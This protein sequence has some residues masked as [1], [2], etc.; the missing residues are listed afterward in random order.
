MRTTKGNLNKAVAG[1]C[2]EATRIYPG[3]AK[4]ATNVGDTSAAAYFP[5]TAT[6][7][8]RHSAAFQ[9]VLN[10]LRGAQRPD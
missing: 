10:R 2:A 6:D 9:A 3:F 7:E 5:N 1:E 8:A 4:Q